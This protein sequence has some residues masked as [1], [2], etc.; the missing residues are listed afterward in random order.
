MTM[1]R[2]AAAIAVLAPVAWGT[3][4][5]TVTGLLP[6]GRPL[7]VATMRVLP[8]GLLLLALGRISSSWR[9]RGDRMAERGPAGDLQLRLVLPLS[10]RGV[11]PATRRRGGSCRRDSAAAGADVVV[12]DSQSPPTPGRAG[13]GGRGC[14]R[15]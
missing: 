2:H 3:T 7:L 4:A 15:S 6:A 12:A 10:D 11:V 13:G 1:K 5:V 9:P 8:A 14:A